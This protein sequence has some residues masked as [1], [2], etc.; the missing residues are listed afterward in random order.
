MCRE[1][2]PSCAAELVI[3]VQLAEYGCR[4]PDASPTRSANPRHHPARS[5]RYRVRRPRLAALFLPTTGGFG[6]G[7]RARCGLGGR[8]RA[9]RRRGPI[10]PQ[11]WAE[12]YECLVE[13]GCLLGNCVRSAA[14]PP[15]KRRARIPGRNGLERRQS[16]TR[17][18][19]N[20]GE[21]RPVP[22]CSALDVLPAFFVGAHDLID[23][24]LLRFF[25]S[26]VRDLA[27]ASVLVATAAVL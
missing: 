2:R 13:R 6:S 9:V 14:G 11:A 7:L 15:L 20:P 24:L 1:I 23:K 27:G 22:H 18:R 4:N 8:R 26:V 21:L 5:N 10:A 25:G 16:E 17:N 19:R 12:G 3:A